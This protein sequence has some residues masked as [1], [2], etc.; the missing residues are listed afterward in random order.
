[1]LHVSGVADPATIVVGVTEGDD[2]GAVERTGTLVGTTEL[3]DV[4]GEEEI[5]PFIAVTRHVICCPI[6]A[7]LNVV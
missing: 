3:L 4:A 5:T 6:S 7:G 1:V 2:E